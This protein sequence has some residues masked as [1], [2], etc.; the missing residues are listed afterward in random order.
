MKL[1][2]GNYFSTEANMEYMSASQ[3]KDFLECEVHGLAKAR[4]E[5]VQET[6]NAML[7]GSY[8]D[9]YFS[10]ELDEFKAKN[11]DMFTKTGELK[12][13]FKNIQEVIT[14]IES[15]EMMMKYLDGEKQKIMTGIINGV[16]YK[17]KV[18]SLLP[19]YIVDQK[20]MSSIKELVWK[21]D[22]NGY[23]RKT[24]FVEAYGY[25]IQGA[26]YQEIVYQNIGKK[27][28]FVLAATTKEENPDKALIQIDQEYLDR[29][30]TAVKALSERY[31]LIK[32]G[33][34]KPCGCGKCPSCRKGIKVKGIVSYKVL[35]NKSDLEKSNDTENV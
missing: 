21:E 31:D 19:N 15:D 26:I 23:N 32:K 35:F 16:P 12:A 3:F 2:Q 33:V 7:F 28:P 10:N 9:A 1:N 24:D 20:I 34:I 5:Y 18:D 25:D 6:S 4:G 13:A 27:L 17:I 14:A 8:V 29:A 22:S 30:L 11:P